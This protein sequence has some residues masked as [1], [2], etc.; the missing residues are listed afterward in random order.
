MVLIAPS[1]KSLFEWDPLEWLKLS[2]SGVHSSI[3]SEIIQSLLKWHVVDLRWSFHELSFLCERPRAGTAT[4]PVFICLLSS[5]RQGQATCHESAKFRANSTCSASF[6]SGENPKAINTGEELPLLHLKE[7]PEVRAL[8]PFFFSCERFQLSQDETSFFSR[9]LDLLT[10]ERAGARVFVEFSTEEMDQVLDSSLSFQNLWKIY[11]FSM[12][13]RRFLSF[14]I[15]FCIPL[16][17]CCDSF[18]VAAQWYSLGSFSEKMDQV[19]ISRF[20][21]INCWEITVLV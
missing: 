4:C 10:E 11:F 18:F 8:C 5:T 13:M 21:S 17:L 12:I 20:C 6:V 16:R 2:K 1:Y 14:Y 19:P 7:A 9:A 3:S 15:Y